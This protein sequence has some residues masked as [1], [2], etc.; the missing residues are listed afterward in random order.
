MGPHRKTS[1]RVRG[2]LAGIESRAR[3]IVEK[4]TFESN[5]ESR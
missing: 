3:K 5:V 2:T 4:H 1:S